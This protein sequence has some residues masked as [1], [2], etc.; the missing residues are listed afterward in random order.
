MFF[1]LDVCT[2]D[3]DCF[4]GG[5]C[6]SMKE[7]SLKNCHCLEGTNGSFCK[8]VIDCKTMDCGTDANCTYDTDNTSAFCRCTNRE[9]KFDNGDKKCK[10]IQKWAFI[11]FYMFR[12]HIYF[13]CIAVKK[14]IIFCKDGKILTKK[15]FCK[16]QKV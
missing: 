5:K 15:L 4:H 6:K 1:I 11:I 7:G 14:T 2:D 10:G 8:N 16:L 12:H 9:L 3:G 13:I